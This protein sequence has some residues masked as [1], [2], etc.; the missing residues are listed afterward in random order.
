MTRKASSYRDSVDRAG[1]C[2]RIKTVYA[3]NAPPVNRDAIVYSDEVKDENTGEYSLGYFRGCNHRISVGC[4]G[5]SL[6]HFDHRRPCGDSVYEV[7]GSDPLAVRPHD[8]ILRRSRKLSFEF[9][10]EHSLRLGTCQFGFC[11]RPDLVFNHYRDSFRTPVHQICP[12][13]EHAVLCKD[14][15]RL[16][17]LM[18]QSAPPRQIPRPE[19][20]K[21]KTTTRPS[22]IRYHPNSLKS[23][24][25][26]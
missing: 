4:C 6:L 22:A 8:R 14:R 25:L 12:T 15:A 24:F 7:C 3:M 17:T 5:T 10:L 21:Y 9:Y 23:C 19:K 11:D 2:D 16:R 26:M 13:G 18:N 20:T 1:I